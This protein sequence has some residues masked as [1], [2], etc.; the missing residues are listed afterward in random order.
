MKNLNDFLEKKKCFKLVCGAGNEDLEEVNDLIKLYYAAGCRFFDLSMNKEILA[1]AQNIAPEAFF[2]VSTGIKGDPHLNKA[3]INF[4]KCRHCKACEIACP[5]K[6]INEKLEINLQKCIGCG[7]CK[8]VCKNNAIKMYAQKTDIKDILPSVL[9]QNP[10]CIELHG[11]TEDEEEITEKWEYIQ[12]Q[13]KGIMSLCLD[14]SKLSNENLLARIKR[15]IKTRKPYTT[16][17]Q[18]DGAPMSGGIDDYK[19]TL[20]AV[21][22]AEIIQNADLAVYLLI[23]G[24]TN[25][26]TPE[27]ANK[28]GIYPHGIAIGSYART[29]KTVEDAR[30]LINACQNVHE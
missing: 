25:S 2:C 5:Q 24:G 7:I 12:S 30:N 8:R 14:R 4:E 26:K 10:D 18:A 3:E 27:L 20:Q 29:L 28:C 6:A 22:M 13:F 19:T 16:I 9:E 21:A 15:L 11:I 1:S 23:S 17:I